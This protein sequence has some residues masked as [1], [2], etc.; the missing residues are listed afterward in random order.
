MGSF[1]ICF[2]FGAYERL[3][4]K[5]KYPKYCWE[6]LCLWNTWRVCLLWQDLSVRRHGIPRV[7]VSLPLLNL[8]SHAYINLH[9][10]RR[11]GIFYAF[12]FH[13][14]C[15]SSHSRRSKFGQAF[16][17]KTPRDISFPMDSNILVIP[18]ENLCLIPVRKN[19]SHI[20]TQ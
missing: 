9:E 2:S 8:C 4:W 13:W 11:E 20:N 7:F 17:K 19:T 10:G 15:T 6:D 12:S 14:W 5:K 16:E 18:I 3:A 1:A